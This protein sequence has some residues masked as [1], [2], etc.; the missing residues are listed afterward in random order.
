MLND[1]A[2]RYSK[3]GDRCR[4]DI[5]LTVKENRVARKERGRVLRDGGLGFVGGQCS[6]ADRNVLATRAAALSSCKA[7]SQTD[8]RRRVS[9][10]RYVS[11][12]LVFV[13]YTC[14]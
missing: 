11:L 4:W 12:V 1:D 6:R 8:E 10:N 2:S 13:L 9:R 7:D 14:W 5:Y 3:V